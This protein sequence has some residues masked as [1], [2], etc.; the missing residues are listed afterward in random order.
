VFSF[1]VLSHHVGFS[2]V[3]LFR[4]VAAR[5]PEVVRLDSLLLSGLSN[6][7]PTFSSQ[8][9]QVAFGGRDLH[10]R[11]PET[12][13]SI[14]R[15]R[16][17]MPPARVSTPQH[18]AVRTRLRDT[19]RCWRPSQKGSASTRRTDLAHPPNGAAGYTAAGRRWPG[20]SLDK[21]VRCN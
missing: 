10:G 16:G 12:C 15:Y 5:R 14:L 7:A 17:I 3:R 6:S 4:A 19:A 8:Q 11:R 9:T 1:P 18:G 21:A 2:V 20:C 13:P